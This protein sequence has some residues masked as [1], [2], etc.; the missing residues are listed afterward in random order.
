MNGFF[1][2]AATILLGINLYMRC[3]PIVL[4]SFVFTWVILIIVGQDIYKISLQNKLLFDYL[5]S[6]EKQAK[7]TKDA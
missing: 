7:E 3:E 1:I 5:K 2:T 6:Q 4:L